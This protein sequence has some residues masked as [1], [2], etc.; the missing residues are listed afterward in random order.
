MI[1]KYINKLKY[2]NQYKQ[3]KNCSNFSNVGLKKNQNNSHKVEEIV[4]LG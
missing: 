2:K 4:K 1:K 3:R